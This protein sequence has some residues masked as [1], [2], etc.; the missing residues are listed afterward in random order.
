M[1]L[2]RTLAYWTNTEL[3]ETMMLQTQIRNLVVYGDRLS[4][5]RYNKGKDIVAV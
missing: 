3:E 5:E 4:M 1:G 2:N